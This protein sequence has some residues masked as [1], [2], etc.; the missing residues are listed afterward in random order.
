L[1]PYKSHIDYDN[2]FQS[3]S[4]PNLLLHDEEERPK[5]KWPTIDLDVADAFRTVQADLLR[6]GE[7]SSDSEDNS[8][9]E[10]ESHKSEKLAQEESWKK[11]IDTLTRLK[12]TSKV[13][14]C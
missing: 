7:T 14:S 9:T 4:A 1:R 13:N 8:E 6:G 11:D 12:S 5:L 10:T 2:P 3:I